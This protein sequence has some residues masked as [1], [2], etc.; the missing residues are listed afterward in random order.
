MF[1]VKDLQLWGGVE[2]TVNR[3]GDQWVDQ[4]ER[5][6][7]HGRL[8][9]LEL[10]HSL[11]LRTLRYG[12]HWERFCRAGSLEI[13]AQPLSRMQRL[14]INPIA[15]LVHHG[16]GP[17]G[18]DLLD[19]R[20]GEK[21]A[22]YAGRLAGRYPWIQ[23]YTPVNEPQTTARFSGLYGH[24][25]PHHRT[26]ASYVRALLNQLRASVLAMRAV[27]AVRSDAL[28]ISTE[29]GGKTWSTPELADLCAEREGRRWLGLDLLCGEVDEE[30]P[31]FEFLRRHGISQREILWF[32]ENPCPPDVIGLNYY[33]TSDR[34][35]DHRTWNYPDWL[36]GGDDGEEPLVD[37][38]AVRL[39]A[40]GIAGAGAILTEAWDRY[41]IPVAITEA[42][43]GGTQEDQV[44]WLLEVWNE[45]KAA[46]A[47]GVNCVAVT[48]WAL[49]GSYDWCSLVTRQDGT[50][51]PGVFDVTDGR[52]VPTPL[53][54]VVQRLT[55]GETPKAHSSGWWR[56]P[57]RLTF[58]AADVEDELEL[59]SLV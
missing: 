59:Q 11:G 52:P 29:D 22:S 3:V 21:L 57:D 15:G 49:L 34:F 28:F 16:S 50:Y 20:F 12:L 46:R 33:L 37:I 58:P 38:E 31:M 43:L 45:A 44:A 4:M 39:R 14:G 53:A 47:S 35:L 36:A 42:H 7:H 17:D 23:C 10:I 13:F 6:G 24:W 26:F 9:D 54:S 56:R 8:D 1:E 27:R 32:A 41:G 2:C 19:P 5:C 25:Y 40:A 51:E 30:H 48:A 18:T 55:R